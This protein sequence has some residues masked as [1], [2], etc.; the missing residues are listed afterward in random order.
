MENADAR[1]TVSV[2]TA[3]REKPANVNQQMT[4]AFS[5]DPTCHVQEK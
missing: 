2:M 1:E 3:G 4:L 5:Q